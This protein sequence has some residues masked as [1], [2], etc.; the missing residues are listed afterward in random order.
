MQLAAL[1]CGW[2]DVW[3]PLEERAAAAGAAPAVACEASGGQRRADADLDP[4]G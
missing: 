1:G 4:P 2:D 3:L